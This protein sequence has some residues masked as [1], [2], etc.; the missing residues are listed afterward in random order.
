MGSRRSQQIEWPDKARIA[1]VLQVAF[2]QFEASNPEDIALRERMVSIPLLSKDVLKQGTQDLL[3]KSWDQFGEVGTWRLV[4]LLN[5]HNVTSTGVF[6]G[7]AIERYPDVVKAFAEG[8]GGREI[9]AHSWA[10]DIP[11]FKLDRGQMLANVRKCID[12]ITKVTGKRPV[13]WVSPGGRTNEHTLGVLADE[14]FL[15]HGDC[16]ISGPFIEQAGNKKLVAMSIPW[17]VNDLM[18][19]RQ[20]VPPSHYVE[21]FCRSFDVLYEEGGQIAGAVAHTTIYGRPFGI[22]AYDQVIRYAKSFPKVWFATRQEIAEW[23][24]ERYT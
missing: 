10:Q 24:L 23:Y 5:R 16:V 8:D 4:E 2:E 3:L 19:V 7:L 1:V 17:D 22:W 14:G 13:G 11:S 12:I 21:L 18:Y 9:C 15:W 20:W 6:S